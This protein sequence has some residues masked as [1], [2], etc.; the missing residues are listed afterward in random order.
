MTLT[1]PARPFR[2]MSGQVRLAGAPSALPCR[3]LILP[4]G[5]RTGGAPIE[6][7]MP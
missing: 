3:C 7:V 4:P 5:W 1:D 2:E 6:D